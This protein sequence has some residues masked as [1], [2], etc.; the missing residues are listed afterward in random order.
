MTDIDFREAA[1]DILNNSGRADKPLGLIMGF[2]AGAE[3]ARMY[4]LPQCHAVLRVAASMRADAAVTIA[5][6]AV[7]RADAAWMGMAV[8][9]A[10]VERAGKDA[11]EQAKA[12][13]IVDATYREEWRQRNPLT[14]AQDIADLSRPAPLALDWDQRGEVLRALVEEMRTREE[15]P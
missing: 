3:L 1:W 7:T 4:D 5:G 15:T 2:E 6:V 12:F 9:E 10:L 11:F 8:V 14:K 13:A